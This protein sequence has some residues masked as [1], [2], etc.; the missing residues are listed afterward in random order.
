MFK[1][2]N[3]QAPSARVQNANTIIQRNN[4]NSS[5]IDI[6]QDTK[7]FGMKR[8][9]Q[10]QYGKILKRLTSLESSS[11]NQNPSCEYQNTTKLLPIKNDFSSN[12][13]FSKDINNTNINKIDDTI[14]LVPCKMNVV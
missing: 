14:S 1:Q 12:L 7:K 8:K 13:D 11:L 4:H 10:E 5:H 2:K 9:R 3:S 6:Y